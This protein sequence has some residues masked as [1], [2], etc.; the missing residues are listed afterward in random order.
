LKVIRSFIKPMIENRRGSVI[1]V[2]SSG[3]L[4]HSNGGGYMALRPES[5]EQPYMSSKAALANL[6]FYLAAEMKAYNIAANIVVPGHTRTTGFDEQ[7]RARIAAGAPPSRLPVKP[8][9]M[10]PVVLFLA[11]QDATGVTGK[12][13]DAL[14]WNA[15]HGLGGQEEWLDRSFSYDALV[16]S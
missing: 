16:T 8:E 14:T 3:I 9:H 12:M 6:T 11:S 5:K 4:Y 2:V 1:S 15:E 10:V 13:F 7:N